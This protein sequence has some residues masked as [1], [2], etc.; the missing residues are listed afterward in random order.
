MR[1]VLM[2]PFVFRDV[3]AANKSTIMHTQKAFLHTERL[4]LTTWLGYGS[5]IGIDLKTCDQSS[6]MQEWYSH[7]GEFHGS[8]GVG[9]EVGCLQVGTLSDGFWL[10][11]VTG[12]EGGCIQDVQVDTDGYFTFLSKAH[13]YD[14]VPDGVRMCVTSKGSGAGLYA[15]ACATTDSSSCTDATD[16]S[17]HKCDGGWSLQT[18]EDVAAAVSAV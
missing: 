8:N 11:Q 12:V 2:F 4:C 15:V 5:G 16:A 13:P 14:T 1:A 17:G 7:D 6:H 9:D 18:L 10:N 3:L